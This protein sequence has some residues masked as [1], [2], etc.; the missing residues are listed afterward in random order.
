VNQATKTVTVTDEGNSI[1]TKADLVTLKTDDATVYIPGTNVIYTI[2]VTNNG[3]NDA[4]NVQVTDPFPTGI[5]IGTWQLE[6]GP[7][8]S[9]FLNHN[10]GVLANG[11]TLTYLVTLTIPIDYTGD[12]VNTV[13]TTSDTNDPD[14]DPT[15]TGCTDTNT[16]YV[17]SAD[18]DLSQTVTATNVSIGDVVT[19]TLTLLNKGPNTATNVGITN[20]IPIGLEYISHSTTKGTYNEAAPT[21]VSDTEY[22]PIGIENVNHK[23]TNET[24]IVTIS[25]VWNVGTIQ[26]GETV[27]LN[28]DVRVLQPTGTVDEHLHKIEV[29][30]TDQLDP[31]NISNTSS[32]VLTFNT[33]LAIVKTVSDASPIVETEIIF[34]ISLTNNTTITATNVQI[35]EILASGYQYVSHTTSNGTYSRFTGIW[36]ISSVTDSTTETLTLTVLVNTSGE[37]ANTASIIALDEVDIDISNN[38]DTV[39]AVPVCLTIY[40]EFSPDGNGVNEFFVID[41]LDQYPNN[42]L[43]VFNRYGNTVYKKKGYDNSWNGISTGR[44]TVGTSKRLP[45]GTYYYVL[46]LGDGTTP[47]TGWLYI[48]R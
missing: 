42:T 32:I 38:T 12:L 48:N 15:C 40:N 11:A 16:Q 13:T 8:S 25:Q 43:E 22:I 39:A 6:S 1:T 29:T 35:E 10:T 14:P 9:G 37:Y 44:L 31:D 26:N 23:T 17:P 27:T 5:T 3:P 20:Y 21:Q 4:T 19:F 47:K 24:D 7:I 46:N 36:E 33:D 34:T 18:L 41:C 2:T 30:S 28:I 45:I